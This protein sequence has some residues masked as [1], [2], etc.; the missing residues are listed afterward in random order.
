M[1]PSEGVEP[2]VSSL[3]ARRLNHFGRDGMVLPRLD[4]NQGFGV[5][6]AAS[7]RLDDKGMGDGPLTPP[8]YLERDSNPH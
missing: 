7:Y 2:S 8:E 4:S 1:V 3:S 6:S 5:Q